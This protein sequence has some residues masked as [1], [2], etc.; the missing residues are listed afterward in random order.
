MGAVVTISEWIYVKEELYLA[1]VTQMRMPMR[2]A[3]V[4]HPLAIVEILMHIA[5]VIYAKT[6][7]VFITWPLTWRK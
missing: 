4:A 2:K 5:S 1:N 6:S 3:R 7:E